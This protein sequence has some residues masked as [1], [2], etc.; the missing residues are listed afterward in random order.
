MRE[1][2]E[3]SQINELARFLGGSK[4]TENVMENAKEMKQLAND[5]KVNNAR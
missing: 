3:E 2:D 4:I 1:M 5:Y